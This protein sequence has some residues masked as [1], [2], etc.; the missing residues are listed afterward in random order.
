[1]TGRPDEPLDDLLHDGPHDL[2][3]DLEVV[4][5][6]ARAAEQRERGR[7]GWF[8]LGGA[9]LALMLAVPVVLT[10][11]DWLPF[12]L[13]SRDAQPAPAVGP[14]LRRDAPLRSEP[15]ADANI[16]IRLDAG[17]LLRLVGRTADGKWVAAAADDRPDLVGW[18][19]ADALQGVDLSAL[20][21]VTAD[22]TA[23]ATASAPTGPS[24]RPDLRLES[25]YSKDN[26]LYI[27]VL[28]AG[29]ADARGT[30]LASVDGAPPVPLEGKADEGLRAGQRIQ[31]AVRDVYVQ[32]R[33][34]VTVT[35]ALD[36]PVTEVDQT[37]NRFSGIVEPDLP[38]DLE[39]TTV[40]RGGAGLVV[41]VKNRSTIPITGSYTITVREPLPSTRLLGRLEQTGTIE[42]GATASVTFPDLR[43]VDVTRILVTL[44][45]DAIQDAVLGNNTYPR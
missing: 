11:T 44:S 33:G 38:A 43:E 2:D 32:I 4:A 30:I 12:E 5:D 9:V 3:H 37:N 21:T 18:L 13:P 29:P 39:L 17:T 14:S 25:A 41:S 6:A 31:A 7:G 16:L 42:A 27:S 24:D 15:R 22:R 8:L 20:T 1:M 36:P 40:E 28:N 19:P 10:R 34:S 35:V 23:T 45:T 26:R